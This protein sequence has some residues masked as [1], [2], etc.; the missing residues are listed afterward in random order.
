MTLVS[1]TPLVPHMAQRTFEC[2]TCDRR[3]DVHLER[4]AAAERERV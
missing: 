4:E 2:Q 3:K 1:L